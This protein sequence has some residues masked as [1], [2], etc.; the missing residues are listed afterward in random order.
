MEKS[1]P[2]EV[3]LIYGRWIGST[4]FVK[5]VA[6]KNGKSER[7]AKKLI[8]DAYRDKQIK[9]HVFPDRTVIYGLTE[10]GPPTSLSITV[11][12]EAIS[13]GTSMRVELLNVPI[14]NEKQK[15]DAY[16]RMIFEITQRIFDTDNNCFL[17]PNFQRPFPGVGFN[18]RS[19]NDYPS[20]VRVKTRM[21]LGGTDLGLISDPKGYYNGAT[22]MTFGPQPEGLVNGNFT[23]SRE[24]DESDRELTLQVSIIAT[25]PSGIW[26]RLAPKSWS[27]KRKENVWFYEPRVFVEEQWPNLL[28]GK[29]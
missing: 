12:N 25:D 11:D 9:K 27:Y 15:L 5:L 8:A 14:N 6:R 29:L 7:W 1:S 2:K 20:R 13:S 28:L 26:H 19:G 4:E 18:I 10:F 24:C 17:P 22:E 23:V 21:I 3:L 16:P